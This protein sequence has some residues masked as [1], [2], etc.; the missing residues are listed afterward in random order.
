MTVS[1]GGT[2]VIAT[3][4]GKSGICSGDSG[5][6]ALSI[7]GTTKETLIV[8]VHSYV[9]NIGTCLGKGYSTRT[10]VVYDFIK[11]NL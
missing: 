7:N 5:G 6:P 10:D 11:A 3:G 9:D 1:P 8:G 2:S 4:D